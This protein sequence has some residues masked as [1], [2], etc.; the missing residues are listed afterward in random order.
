MKYIRQSNKFKNIK[1]VTKEGTFDSKKEYNWWLKLKKRA[2]KGEISHLQRQVPITLVEKSKFGR[3][4][5]YIADF[6]YEE[7]KTKEMCV[8]DVKGIITDVFKLKARLFAEK[9]GFEIKI[10]K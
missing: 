4:I 10:L 5:K 9:Y 1:V 6:T 2:E 7:K 3:E 8:C